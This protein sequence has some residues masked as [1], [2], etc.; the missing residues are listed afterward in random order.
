MDRRGLTIDPNRDVFAKPKWWEEIGATTRPSPY[1]TASWTYFHD[2]VTEL[3]IPVVKPF[4]LDNGDN[5]LNNL[6]PI[7]YDGGIFNST[8]PIQI[9]LDEGGWNQKPVIADNGDDFSTNI[10][11]ILYN[12]G[13]FNTNDIREVVLDELGYA[14]DQ[15]IGDPTEYVKQYFASVKVY[16]GKASSPGP[17]EKVVMELGELSNEDDT[18]ILT[19]QGDEMLVD[20]FATK[21]YEDDRGQLLGEIHYEIIGPLLTI[22]DW[23]HYKWH[24]ASPVKKAFKVLINDIP[25]CVD[26]VTVKDTPTAFWRHLGFRYVD[27]GDDMLVY[28]NKNHSV[29]PY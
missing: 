9:V 26:I 19:E 3:Q 24:D 7:G 13:L 8:E 11:T 18:L 29:V 5:I 21:E 15:P 28:D 25:D 17:L 20:T 12:G 2:Y 22:T 23:S 10:Y 6:Y 16:D 4:A 14:S 27:K 1:A